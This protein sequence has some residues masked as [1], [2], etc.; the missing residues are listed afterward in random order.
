MPDSPKHPNRKTRGTRKKTANA[1]V[2]GRVTALR[3]RPARPRVKEPDQTLRAPR[4]TPS[5]QSV[6][7]PGFPDLE[8]AT[9]YLLQ[10]AEDLVQDGVL[11]RLPVEP[12]LDGL[13]PVLTF[14]YARADLFREANLGPEVCGAVEHIAEELQGMSDVPMGADTRLLRNPREQEAVSTGALL[15]TVYRDAIRRVARGP[16][17]MAAR[18]AFGMGDSAE[19]RHPEHVVQGIELF[20]KGAAQHPSYVAE[21]GLSAKQIEG[22]AAQRRVILGR[23]KL[24]RDQGAPSPAT[25]HRA[26]V[27]HG[28]LEYFF[29]RFSAAVSAKLIDHPEE[30]VRGLRLVPRDNTNRAGGQRATD[31]RV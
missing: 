29:D 1:P 3:P 23:L 28:A 25:L 19:M 9:R 15:L 12:Y 14:I 20:L 10:H 5:V 16:R 26:R 2:P 7:R 21:A 17:G 8:S 31:P 6:I 27:L 4:K 22:L 24:R 18:A 11:P 30:R 13:V